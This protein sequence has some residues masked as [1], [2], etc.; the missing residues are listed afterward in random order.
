MFFCCLRSPHPLGNSPTFEG[1]PP[2]SLPIRI[3]WQNAPPQISGHSPR[4]Q[5]RTL[6]TAAGG[7]KDAAG[8]TDT[9][10]DGDTGSAEASTSRGRGAAVT[11][12]FRGRGRRGR[13]GC[14]CSSRSCSAQ[15]PGSCRR[16]R[17]LAAAVRRYDRELGSPDGLLAI[18]NSGRQLRNLGHVI[19]VLGHPVRIL[20]LQPTFSYARSARWAIVRICCRRSWK[21]ETLC[22]YPRHKG[23]TVFSDSE[24]LDAS[25]EKQPADTKYGATEPPTHTSTLRTEILET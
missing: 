4:N 14:S 16:T 15:G 8:D 6:A 2:R 3:V 19:R 7:C 25:S 24:I 22:G 18:R 5:A 13:G 21:C 11:V 20:E 12:G 23:G 1:Q 9:A 17:R 10:E